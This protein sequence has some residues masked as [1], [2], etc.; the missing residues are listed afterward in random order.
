MDISLDGRVAIVTGGGTG[1]GRG[2]ARALSKAGAA[3]A[4]T[5][6]RQEPLAEFVDETEAD[7][8][9]ALAVPCDV[10][11][12]E[13]VDACVQEVVDWKGSVDILVNNA[14]IYPPSPFLDVEEEQWLDIMDTNVNGPF[15]FSQA[16]AR[17]M[18][19]NGRGRI[20]NILSPSAELGFGFVSA[21]GTSKGALASMTRNLAAELTPFGVT[22]NSLMPGPSATDTFVGLFTQVGVDLM[23]NGL[24]VKRACR[25]EDMAGA[26]VYL[27]SDASEYV[28][29]ATLAVDGGMTH[30]FPTGG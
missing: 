2:F 18:T 8:R 13:Q 4:V 7:G 21:Y 26:L 25:D 27:A 11:S 3:V 14:G 19:E 16:C 17:R 30:T 12:R 22:V 20:I 24:P 15:R 10:R 9:D 5:G 28:T 29:G 1:L 6:R 23:A